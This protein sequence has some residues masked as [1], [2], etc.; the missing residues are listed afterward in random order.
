MSVL[1]VLLYAYLGVGFIYAMYIWLFAGD[2]WYSIPVNIL[3]GPVVIIYLSIK[4]LRR[5]KKQTIKDVFTGKKGV[6]FDMDGTLIYSTEYW[7]RALNNIL[8]TIGTIY[9]TPN[10]PEGLNI[11]EKWGYII[12]SGEVKTK[13]SIKDLAEHTEKEFLKLYKEPDVIEGWWEFV[14]FL[15]NTKKMKIGLATNTG[16]GVTE[17]ILKRLGATQVFDLIITGDDVKK[18]KPNPEMHKKAARGLGLKVSEVVVFEDTEVGSK[19]AKAAGMDV[20]VIWDGDVD[21]EDYPKGID[22]F[23]SDYEGLI[24]FVDKDMGDYIDDVQK[25]KITEES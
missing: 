17:V 20:I 11:I 16:R 2:L 22:N 1:E 25:G 7:S 6:I 21:Q 9:Y 4:S 18:R 19:G 15:K 14:E 13:L 5:R 3:G 23:I 12:D 10:F 24:D 8:Q